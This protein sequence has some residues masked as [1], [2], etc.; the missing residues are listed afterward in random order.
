MPCHA[1]SPALPWACKQEVR[2]YE[3]IVKRQELEALH[4]DVDALRSEMLSLEDELKRAQVGGCRG[5]SGSAGSAAW[6]P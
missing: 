6:T 1:K 5:T 3:G 4:V 2:R